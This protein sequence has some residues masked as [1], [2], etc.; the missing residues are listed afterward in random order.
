[1][2]AKIYPVAHVGHY[3]IF[4]VLAN[5]LSMVYSFGLQNAIPVCDEKDLLPVS[6][7]YLV[8]ST[9]LAFLSF[10]VILSVDSSYILVP[11]CAL[12]IS[13]CY[14]CEQY[15]LRYGLVKMLSGYRVWNA[16]LIFSLPAIAGLY[17]ENPTV[18]IIYGSV[19]GYAISFSIISLILLDRIKLERGS[20]SLSSCI[21]KY[22]NYYYMGLGRMLHTF[23]YSLPVIVSGYFFSPVIAANVNFAQKLSLAPMQ[24]IGGSVLQHLTVMFSN[25]KRN[26][27]SLLSGVGKELYFL[28]IMSVLSFLALVFIAPLL[29]DYFFSDEWDDSIEYI[30][31]F[32][33]LI[34]PMVVVAPFTCVYQFV[35]MQRQVLINQLATA[36]GAIII[37]GMSIYLDDFKTGL[38]AF[39]IYVLAV[40]FYIGI[41]VLK[42]KR[43]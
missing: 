6:K 5:L 39:S 28:L 35:G 32:T 26:G 31:I 40:Y 15:C 14:L 8:F 25:R 11:F 12:I 27:E 30:Y 2:L 1:M 22:S 7:L 23:A 18:E 43:T 41:T 10:I 36:C 38:F 24:I 33:V 34:I 4:I 9:L 29:I 13:V 37:F 16:L 19:V 3:S 20:L 17:I 21:S 42:I